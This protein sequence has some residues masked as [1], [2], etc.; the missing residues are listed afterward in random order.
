MTGDLITCDGAAVLVALWLLCLRCAPSLRQDTCV[1]VLQCRGQ[2]LLIIPPDTPASES[3]AQHE[4]T[5]IALCG[6]RTW[7]VRHDSR[8]PCLKCFAKFCISVIRPDLGAAPPLLEVSEKHSRTHKPASCF[9]CA[10]DC[11][12][13]EARAICA[14]AVV[15]G[16]LNVRSS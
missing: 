13:T 15:S 5:R 3:T 11:C 7:K 14:V 8:G 6:W 12:L 2:C 10:S 1:I 16:F 9:N 4:H